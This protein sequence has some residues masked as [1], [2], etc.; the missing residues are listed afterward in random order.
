MDSRSPLSPR[1]SAFSIAS[2]V[3][4][5]A[6]E[7]TARLSPGSSNTVKLHRLLES[8]AG[9]HFSTVTRDME[10]E[11]PR[12]VYTYRRPDPC[13]CCRGT[14]AKR[15]GRARAQSGWRELWQGGLQASSFNSGA[16]EGRA[17]ILPKACAPSSLGTQLQRPAHYQ[18]Q[19]Q[20]RASGGREGQERR[21]RER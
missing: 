7:R 16:E 15:V 18:T 6:A 3:A 19:T 10:G 14:P 9:M 2:L 4:A 1:A 11:P 8:P 20:K 17:G 21:I 12:C 5:E 13:L